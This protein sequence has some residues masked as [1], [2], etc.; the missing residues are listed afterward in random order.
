MFD[1]LAIIGIAFWLP[2]AV[3]TEE[4]LNVAFT[5]YSYKFIMAIG[6]IPLIYLAH[7]IIDQILKTTKE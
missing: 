3:K 6:T 5:N 1:S 7:S 4:F 2:G